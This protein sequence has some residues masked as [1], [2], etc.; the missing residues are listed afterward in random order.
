MA[1]ITAPSRPKM[2]Q[3]IRN[4]ITAPNPSA[5]QFT[6]TIFY[7]SSLYSFPMLF[8]PGTGPS[9]H[10]GD[11]AMVTRRPYF[12]N[13]KKPPVRDTWSFYRN[14]LAG[15]GYTC[16]MKRSHNRRKSAFLIKNTGETR[17]ILTQNKEILTLFLVLLI[18]LVLS[19]RFSL[20]TVIPALVA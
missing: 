1:S 6:D 11:L 14:C 3:P 19:L 18:L 16:R 15:L 12:I 10:P 9:H 17:W 13:Y 2:N 5:P 4:A 7:H 20:C 8:S